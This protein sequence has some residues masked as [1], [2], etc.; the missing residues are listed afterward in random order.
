MQQA[1]G[2]AEFGGERLCVLAQCRAPPTAV[3][4]T[5]TNKKRNK[6]LPGNQ[7]EERRRDR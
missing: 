6:V 3:D 2:Y 1:L 7:A 4:G 5:T